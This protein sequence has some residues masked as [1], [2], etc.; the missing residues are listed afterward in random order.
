MQAVEMPISERLQGRSRTVERGVANTELE[1]R[2]D[3][4]L[5]CPHANV[6]TIDA[7]SAKVRLVRH[8]APTQQPIACGIAIGPAGS[9][10]VAFVGVIEA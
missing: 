2:E 6:V 7:P 8:P 3:A 10:H 9:L 4:G 5:E 1:P